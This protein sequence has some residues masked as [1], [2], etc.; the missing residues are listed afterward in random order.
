MTETSTA[1]DT[2]TK[3]TWDETW[4]RIGSEDML[5]AK[6]LIELSGGNNREYAGRATVVAR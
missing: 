2:T 6:A 1:T 4:A 5:A 3:P